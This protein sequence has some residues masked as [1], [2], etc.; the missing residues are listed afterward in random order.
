[1]AVYIPIRC[2]RREGVDVYYE[3]SQPIHGPHPTEPKRL[4]EVGQNVGVVRLNMDTRSVSRVSG[5]E[6]DSGFCYTRVQ[7]KLLEHLQE[8]GMIPDVTCYAA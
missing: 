6:W 5:E 4:I 1:M 2:V 3:Y 7:A 8:E